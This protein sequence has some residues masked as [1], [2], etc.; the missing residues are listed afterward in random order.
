MTFYSPPGVPDAFFNGTESVLGGWSGTFNEFLT[1]YN[2]QI[3]IPVPCRIDLAGSSYG[4]TTQQ[5]IVNAKVTAVDTIPYSNL[6]L[7]MAF[8]ETNINYKWG[9]LS[10]V[11]NLLRKMLP[12]AYGPLF[13]IRSPGQSYSSTQQMN[14]TTGYKDNNCEVIVFVQHD[15]TKKVLVSKSF[16]LNDLGD[17]NR[18]GTSDIQDIVILI[19]YVYYSGPPPASLAFADVNN[20]CTLDVADIELLINYIFYAG[21]NPKIGCAQ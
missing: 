3:A 15:V 17:S 5:L 1:A 20:D 21:E 9:G 18:D 19:N 11:N 14:V 6:R 8:T 7:R 10:K 13:N 12:D 4:K 16:K 2:H